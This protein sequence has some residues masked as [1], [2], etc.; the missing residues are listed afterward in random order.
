MKLNNYTG[1][2]EKFLILC[3]MVNSVKFLMSSFQ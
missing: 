1:I 3:A 2:P